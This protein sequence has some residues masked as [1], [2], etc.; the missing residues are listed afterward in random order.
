MC[1]RAC[2][3]LCVQQS[4][5]FGVF[6]YHL[7]R[8][9]PMTSHERRD[10]SN[11]QPFDCLSNMLF[12][13]TSK[14]TSKIRPHHW[15]FGRGIHR[16]HVDSPQNGPVMWKAFPFCNAISLDNVLIGIPYNITYMYRKLTDSHNRYSK[17]IFCLISSET[18]TWDQNRGRPIVLILHP[19]AVPISFGCQ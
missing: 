4:W 10:V 9:V 6:L 7:I 18:N 11:H 1:A 15:P 8:F 14:T 5:F 16:W 12:K 19:R 17:H 2:L 3:C 13:I